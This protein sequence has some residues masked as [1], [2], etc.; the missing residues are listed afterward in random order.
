MKESF[1]HYL[2]QFKKFDVTSLLTTEGL[3]ITLVQTGY[4][5]Q[6]AGPDFFNAQLIIGTQKWAGNVEIHLKSSDWYVHHHE[7]DPAYENVIL[8]VVWEHDTEVFRKNNTKIP[9][10]ELSN[11]VD[12]DL[13]LQYQKLLTPKK[14]INCENDI[15]TIDDFTLTYWK[16]QLFI[17]RMT[18]RQKEIDELLVQTTND[19]EAVFFLLLAKGF[20]LNTNGVIF[21]ELMQSIPYAII[22]KEKFDP[23]QLEALF[24]G[25]AQLLEAE[26]E[27]LYFKLLNKYWNNQQQKY[28]FEVKMVPP[29][30]FF[31]HRPD[32]F[33][34]IRLSQLAQLLHKET[35]LFQKCMNAQSVSDYY[36]LFAV[37]VS[38]YWKAHYVFDKEH[39]QSNK[40]LTT[41]FIDLLLINS[42]LPVLFAYNRYQG[43]D[44]IEQLISIASQLKPEK[45]TIIQKFMQLEIS[46][47]SG[48]DTQSYLHLKKNYC[49]LNKCL[50]C[51]I[52]QK[53]INFTTTK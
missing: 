46:C 13:L 3:P 50:H 21:F 37:S 14:W 36:D 51:A 1:L 10:L 41:S 47:Q 4:Y 24:F 28:Q 7:L 32:N 43:I 35:Q 42:V 6:Q 16:E 48:F 44:A 19:W 45:N 11:Y 18:L 23:I 38:D 2:W 27:D 49:D 30:Q 40:K 33:P 34:T 22:R 25:R 39:K 17:D 31:K 15:H 5:L 52:G 26:C 9:V 29:V 12:N 8:H 20:G 53:L